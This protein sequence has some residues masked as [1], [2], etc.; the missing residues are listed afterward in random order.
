MSSSAIRA[1]KA[2]LEFF[3]EDKTKAGFDAVKQ[4]LQSFAGYIGGFGAALT[5]AS[6]VALGGLGTAL[7]SFSEF[8]GNISDAAN[9][10]G[11]GT[12]MLQVLGFEAE[13]TGAK[14][15]DVES[16]AKTMNKTIGAAANGNAKAQKSLAALGLSSAQ[17]LKLSPDERFTAIAQAISQ[18][19]DPSLRSAAA[20][21]VFGNSANN[22]MEIL[23]GGAD[24][25]RSATREL[26]AS[27]LILSQTDLDNEGRFG[28]AWHKLGATVSA[29]WRLVGAAV[30]P[31]AADLLE[32]LQEWVTWLTQVADSHRGL[33]R[34]L[35]I[36]A[37]IIGAVGMALVTVAGI[38]MG[39]SVV[40]GAIPTIVAGVGAAFAF[41]AAAVGFLL[42]PVGMAIAA[43]T[44]LVALLP[45]FA[46]VVDANFF[47]GKGLQFIMDMFRAV[48]RVGTQTVG[49]IFDALANGNWGLAGQILMAGLNV[50]F[51]AGWSA[52][53]TGAVAATSSILQ[54]LTNLFGSELI[55][56]VLK[57]F[58]A[59]I[60]AI[61]SAADKVGL[62]S[63][64]IST[65]GLTSLINDA[66]RGDAA[67]KRSLDARVNARRRA[68]QA[69]VAAAQAALDALTD[70]AAQEKAKRFG[71][72]DQGGKGLGGLVADPVRELQQ[73][74]S[75][76]ATNSA[77]AARLSSQVPVFDSIKDEL[78]K[79]TSLLQQVADNT[80]DLESEGL[81]D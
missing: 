25:I 15:T 60:N 30:A 80:E 31:I 26:Q 29:A 11:L 28:D 18:I 61:N 53:K 41:M 63:W 68:G 20:M 79:Q 56:L 50:A 5:A 39:F 6:G 43:I 9:R 35:A 7:M 22:I 36:G 51:V 12:E 81:D 65:D 72:K 32:I 64:K 57:G 47:D 16:A 4:R 46:Y 17:L 21:K 55:G 14:L 37:V 45:L 42:S 3:A 48:W 1:G 73:R 24:G 59:V 10:T 76:G 40:I 38:A 58:R 44:A 70:V 62:D 77:Q 27:G 19:S 33:V 75:M 66:A 54:L 67:F 52:L 23:M 34:S 49:G 74:I 8:A 71:P 13:R 78:G 2:F 69:E